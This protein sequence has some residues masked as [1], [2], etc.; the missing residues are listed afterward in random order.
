MII[1]IQLFLLKHGRTKIYSIESYEGF[2]RTSGKDKCSAVADLVEKGI[3]VV[4][5]QI[6][7]NLCFDN[8]TLTLKICKSIFTVSGFFYSLQNKYDVF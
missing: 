8:I 6:I 2:F 4:K 3:P 5:K 1:V 7:Q